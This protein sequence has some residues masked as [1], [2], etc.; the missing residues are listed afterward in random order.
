MSTLSKLL[1]FV[2]GTMWC[3]PYKDHDNAWNVSPWWYIKQGRMKQK[4]WMV[5]MMIRRLKYK[6]SSHTERNLKRQLLTWCPI[7]Y[8][9][10][11][12]MFVQKMYMA[13]TCTC[14]RLKDFYKARYIVM[15]VKWLNKKYDLVLFK[16]MENTNIIMIIMIIGYKILN[17]IK[18][19]NQN[20]STVFHY[21]ALNYIWTWWIQTNFILTDMSV[22]I[23]SVVIYSYK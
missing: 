14:F 10:F 4:I 3:K 7:F 8:N 1:H 22:W 15:N 20:K 12:F 13:C 23:T 11:V 6:K 16:A 18:S 19:I 5:I 2:H 9:M 21:H 17:I